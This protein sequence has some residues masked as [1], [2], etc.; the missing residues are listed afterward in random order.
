MLDD[1]GYASFMKCHLRSLV[2][3]LVLVY[4]TFDIKL[5]ELFVCFGDE[6]FTGIFVLK[7]IFFPYS[8][9][10]FLSS[11]VSFAVKMLLRLIMSFWLIFFSFSNFL[12]A[13]YKIL[14]I[15]PCVIQ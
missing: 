15:V 3:F 13:Y 11:R 6:F 8:E 5:L 9:C 12:M 1:H 4:F 2:A 14:S 7:Y 10:V